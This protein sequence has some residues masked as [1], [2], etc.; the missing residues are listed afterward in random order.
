MSGSNAALAYLNDDSYSDAQLLP[1]QV[2][3]F[4]FI[5]S[6]QRT[7]EAGEVVETGDIAAAGE[8][9]E[10]EE[11][12]RLVIPIHVLKND[13]FIVILRQPIPVHLEGGHGEFI[14]IHEESRV[15]G[16]GKDI[17]AAVRDFYESFISVYLSYIQSTEP[18][19]SGGKQYADYLGH[20]VL[21]IENIHHG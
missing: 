16:S 17:G 5:P 13:Q 15:C 7:G 21:N 9:T 10:A 14:A 2:K 6:S 11:E 12:T 20:L 4:R 18:L 8:P 19:S 1:D 3:P